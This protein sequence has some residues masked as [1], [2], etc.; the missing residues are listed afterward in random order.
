MS[1]A[2]EV[3][4]LFGAT[5]QRGKPVRSPKYLA[6]IRRQASVVSGR[7]GCDPCH[8]GPHGAGQKSADLSAIPL[9]R[10]EH[11][12]FDA[13]PRGFEAR[14]GLDVASLV[15]KFNQLWESNLK[16]DE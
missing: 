2:Y 12:Q 8:T 14:H 10:R 15:L 6:F 7:G 5:Y 11:D 4:P 16:G 3:R 1:T 13:D 9:T